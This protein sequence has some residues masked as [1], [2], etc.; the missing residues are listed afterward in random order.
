MRGLNFKLFNTCI[1]VLFKEVWSFAA[2]KALGVSNAC[3]ISFSVCSISL[4]SK[5]KTLDCFSHTSVI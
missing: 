2:S 4:H 5:G 3:P 1:C